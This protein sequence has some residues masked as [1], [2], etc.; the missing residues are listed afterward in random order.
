MPDFDV[1][2]FHPRFEEHQAE[3]GRRVVTEEEALEAWYG[4]RQ[5]VRNKKS[6]TGTYLMLGRTDAGRSVT[7]VLVGTSAPGVWQGYTAWDT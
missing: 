1:L 2:T 5:V 7:V 3:A 6:A 4:R